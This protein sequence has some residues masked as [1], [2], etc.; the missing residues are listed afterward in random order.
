MSIRHLVLAGLLA[1][2]TAA[3][4]TPI[5]SDNFDSDVQALNATNFNGGWTVSNGTVDIIG[6]GGAWDLIPGNGN[7]VDLDGST[8]QAGVLSKTLNLVA[9]TTYTATF[10]LAGNH[11]GY[12]DDVVDVNFGSSSLTLTR[13]SADA[14]T[15]E[16]LS[17]TAATTGSYT[18]S[19]HNHG[20]DNVGALLD[21]VSV[22]AVPEPASYAMLLGGLGLL[23]FAA[24]RRQR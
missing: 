18:L 3:Q 4:A 15:A 23:G 19:F 14:L 22:S 8:N 6:V 5:F 1:G 7:Y 10:D 13:A 9:G 16:S 17:F 11:R 24:R 20:G 12:A 2:A 21:N